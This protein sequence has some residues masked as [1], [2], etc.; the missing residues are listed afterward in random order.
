M[1][2]KSLF[3]PRIVPSFVG[4]RTATPSRMYVGCGYL[5]MGEATTVVTKPGGNPLSPGLL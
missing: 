3:D 1:T 4:G 2:G 5:S